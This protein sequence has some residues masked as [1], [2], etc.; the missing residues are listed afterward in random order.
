[1]AAPL[2]RLDALVDWERRDRDAGMRV[3]LAPAADLLAR[4]GAPQQGRPLVHL[5]GT[6][7]KGSTLAWL[8]AA[9]LA[10]GVRTALFSSPHVESVTERLRL[11][12]RDV[13]AE[14]LARGLTEALDAHEAARTANTPAASASWFDLMIAG[15]ARAALEADLWLVE[16]GLGGRLDSTN[17]FDSTVAGLTSVELE[18][19]AVLGATREAIA[20][21][22]AGIARPQ[23]AFVVGLDPTD[24]AGRSAAR[25][26]DG[27]GA[28]VRWCP[29][30][31]GATDARNRGLAR[32][33]LEELAL[34]GVAPG[35]VAALDGLDE[36]PRLPGRLERWRTP[37]GV[38]VVLDGAHVPESLELLLGA[39]GPLGSGPLHAVFSCARDK[40]REAML[41]VLGPRVETLLCTSLSRAGSV[42]G[43]TLTADARLLGFSADCEADPGRALERALRF[44]DDGGGTVLVT[45]SLH[46][47]GPARVH[48]RSCGAVPC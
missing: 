46:L 14:V 34:V 45:G 42:P 8:E 36:V 27:L 2:A 19:T 15:S 39:D 32:A 16:V 12:G 40:R 17:A 41:K 28:R 33:L 38:L 13:D 47:I 48:L 1:M 22:K 6:K 31:S 21:E 11:D 10:T 26:A 37:A 30:A 23:K 35:A 18:H 7:G 3:T 9:L 29:P 4:L 44:A 20:A 24:P 5:A 43:D 25:V